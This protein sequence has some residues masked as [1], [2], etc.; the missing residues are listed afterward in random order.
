MNYKQKYI[1]N[2]NKYLNLKKQNRGA[3]VQFLEDKLSILINGRLFP[4][5]I[6]P[7]VKIKQE[8][9][10]NYFNEI[11]TNILYNFII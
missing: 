6:P 11:L 2:K 8:Y 5:E 10:K 3:Y 7:D 9:N 4:D 1:K